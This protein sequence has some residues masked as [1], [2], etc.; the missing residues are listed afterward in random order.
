MAGL[1]K[2]PLAAAALVVAAGLG[3]AAWATHRGVQADLATPRDLHGAPHATSDACARCHPGQHES[4]RRTFHR[5]MTQEASAESVLG[6]FDDASFV[7]GGVEA[8]MERSAG[9]GYRMRFLADGAELS[10]AEVVRTVGSH[11][12]QQYLARDG[13]VLFRL[14]MAWHVEEGR[15]FHM[16]GA[17]LTPDPPEPAPGEHIDRADYYRHVVRWNDNCVF[18]HNVGPDPGR[19]GDRFE[20]EVEELG[21]ACE[22]C[23][24]PADE[25]ARINA[26]PVRRYALH[27]S[28]TADPTI[29]NPRRL[30]PDRSAEV[31]GRCHGQRI[32]DDV[33]RFLDGG[34][35]F[36]PG[37]R[38]ADYSRPLARDTPLDGDPTAFAARFWPDGTARLT[39]YEYQGLLASPCDGLTCTSCHG[40]HEGDP[41]GQLRPALVGDAQCAQCHAD[42]ADHSGHTT[43]ACVDCHMPRVV[44]GLVGAYRSHRIEVPALDAPG[45]P[46]ACSLCHAERSTDWLARGWARLYGDPPERPTESGAPVR[47]D[48]LAGD[49]IERAMAAAALGRTEA[50]VKRAWRAGLLLD[51]LADDPYPAV[52]RMAWR[53]LRALHPDA[54]G[55]DWRSYVPTGPA[56]ARRAW[57]REAEVSLDV[58][59]PDRAEVAPLRARAAQQ[60]IF[61]GE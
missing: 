51:T 13:D 8:R 9:G 37:D 27:L 46:D 58:R 3:W 56:E 49:P 17:F 42:E 55:L 36:V 54:T 57:V 41:S 40:M 30:S 29:V 25:H 50:L 19:R 18:C 32:T 45:R 24:G 38:L 11:R 26:N 48:L 21:V 6:D 23:H 34:D 20:T 31:C 16:N 53:S 47:D 15:W 2:P 7:Y 4:W 60:A 35:P 12:Y 33:G 14:P 39:A 44:Y 1:G 10:R 61:I 43:T 22:A 59:R 5:T 52:R 28:E